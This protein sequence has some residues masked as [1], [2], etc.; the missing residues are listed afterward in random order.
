MRSSLVVTLAGILVCSALAWAS[1]LRQEQT[2]AAASPDQNKPEQSQ[3]TTNPPS[4][5]APPVANH[6][7]SPPSTTREKAPACPKPRGLR[8]RKRKAHHSSNGDPSKVVVRNGGAKEDSAQLAPAVNPA[9]AE[10]ERAN[11]ARLLATTSA[12]LKQVEGRQ[13]TPAQQSMVDE[14]NTYVQQARAAAASADT[15]RAQ[16]LADKARLLSEELTRK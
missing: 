10:T 8:H 12:N 5:P 16:T 1:T 3:P 2:P 15:N 13:L 6:P 11:T 9:Q 4:E 7:A 14:I